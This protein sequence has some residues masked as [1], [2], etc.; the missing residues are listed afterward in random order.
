MTTTGGRRAGIPQAGARAGA[1]LAACAGEATVL[2][3]P[4][5]GSTEAQQLKLTASSLASRGL[6]A[7]YPTAPVANIEE[8]LAQL[9]AIVRI[10][11]QR[12][13]R[14]G[15]FAALYR[16]ATLE[17]WRGIQRGRFDDGQRMD[18][19]GTAFANRYFAAF[20][21]WQSGG[22]PPRCWREAFELTRQHGTIILQHV[23]MGVN[24]HINGDLAAAAAEA[25]PGA[26]IFA[27]RR[28]YD[29]INDVLIRVLEDVQSAVDSLSPELDLLDSVGG[30]DDEQI[31]EFSIR[32]ARGA[33]WKSAVMLANTAPPMR[34]ALLS[35]LDVGAS[36][37]GAI[38]AQPPPPLDV[39]VRA[40]SASEL[41]DAAAVIAVLDGAIDR[42]ALERV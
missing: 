10:A 29:R 5:P 30:R 33:A 19:F 23:L 1:L 18:R 14:V 4:E 3:V 28:D 20:A 21:A 39:V 35:L 13:E 42:P 6:R 9:A 37:L 12:K 7:R 26:S 24:A 38:I 17:V 2:Q 8:A 34:E 32:E 15:Y 31:L 41:A 36:A 25:A 22:E 11:Q 40:I 27:L 16:Q